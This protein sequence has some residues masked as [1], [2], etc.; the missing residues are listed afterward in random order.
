MRSPSFHRHKCNIHHTDSECTWLDTIASENR[1]DL[2]LVGSA[3]NGNAQHLMHK[4]VI[5][6]S[7]INSH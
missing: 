5:T 3:S 7:D 4:S 1:F 6:I 2:I